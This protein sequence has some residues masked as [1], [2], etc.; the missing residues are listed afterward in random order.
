MSVSDVAVR[1]FHLNKKECQRGDCAAASE[2]KNVNK[3]RSDTV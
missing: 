3:Q 2:G 1:P